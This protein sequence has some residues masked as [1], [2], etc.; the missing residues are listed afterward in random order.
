MGMLTLAA[1]MLGG[2]VAIAPAAPTAAAP[3]AAVALD[4]NALLLPPPTD[5]G[6]VKVAVALHVLN[7][8]DIDEVKERFDLTGY[9]LADWRDPRLAYHPTGPADG[10]RALRLGSVWQPQLVLIN[11]SGPRNLLETSLKVEPGG[12][13]EYTERFDA[14]MTSTFELRPFPFDSQRLDVIVH[15]FITQQSVIAF[16]ASD[17]PVWTAAEFSSYSSLESWEFRSLTSSLGHSRT[18]RGRAIP[19]ARFVLT[20]QRRVP[21]YIW[22]VFLPLLLMVMVSWTVFWFDPGEPS[23]QVQIAVT[24][25]LTIIAFAFAIALTLPRVPYLTFADGFF[26]SCYVFAFLAM[27]ELTAVHV[28]YR[29]QRRELALRIRYT[30]RRLIPAAFVITVAVLI[31]HFLL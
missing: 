4:P 16:V 2:R 5:G 15:P 17:Q 3:A 18:A 12:E 11:S 22:K 20:I 9:L 23:S 8:S 31:V 14:T 6:P 21:F 24:T 13:V 7:L 30:A 1:A 19:E 10:F 28:A 26:L 25:I 27:V 29:G